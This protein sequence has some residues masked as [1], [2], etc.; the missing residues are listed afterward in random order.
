M[1]IKRNSLELSQLIST[2]PGN[3]MFSRESNTPRLDSSRSVM[4]RNPLRRFI[5]HVITSIVEENGERSIIITALDGIEKNS[6]QPA[7]WERFQIACRLKE[8]HGNVLFHHAKWIKSLWLIVQTLVFKRRGSK[9]FS[10]STW[11]IFVNFHEGTR[12]VLR[13]KKRFEIALRCLSRRVFTALLKANR[14]SWMNN[15][16]CF[17]CERIFREFLNFPNISINKTQ[18]LMRS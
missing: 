11:F 5:F 12:T 18:L 6:L 13:R 9:T 3:K 10:Y 7:G 8:E 2:F 17:S 15:F 4:K 1:S 14:I 16:K